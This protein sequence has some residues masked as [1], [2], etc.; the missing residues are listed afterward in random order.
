MKRSHVVCAVDVKSLQMVQ[1]THRAHRSSASRF[2][3]GCGV[4]EQN[5]RQLLKF[6]FMIKPNV[7]VWVLNHPLVVLLGDLPSCT[8]HCVLTDWEDTGVFHVSFLSVLSFASNF[9]FLL[10][11]LCIATTAE[12]ENQLDVAQHTSVFMFVFFLGCCHMIG[13]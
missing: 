11:P 6:S 5:R 3:R 2:C 12:R 7:L 1:V 8:E 10:P 13:W 4:R 9:S